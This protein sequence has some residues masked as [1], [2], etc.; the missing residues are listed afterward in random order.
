MTTRPRLEDH[1]GSNCGMIG[2]STIEYTNYNYSYN[3]GDPTTI[4]LAHS[5][6][7]SRQPRMLGILRAAP[8]GIFDRISG[9]IV[10]SAHRWLSASASASASFIVFT[11]GYLLREV[12]S[13][14]D[15][16][17]TDYGRRTCRF[18]EVS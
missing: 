15:L 2:I 9:G 11:G 14:I 16:D 4:G 1:C 17:Q 12:L 5:F 18:R 13:F 7:Q 6:Q 3:W 8:S 10:L